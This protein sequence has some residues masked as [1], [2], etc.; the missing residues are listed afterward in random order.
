MSEIILKDGKEKNEAKIRMIGNKIA[1]TKD[2]LVKYLEE[3][4][5]KMN[6][7]V[8]L[9]IAKNSFGL[10]SV[11]NLSHD[12]SKYIQDSFGRK[13]MNVCLTNEGKSEAHYG[14]VSADSLDP[15]VDRFL[16]NKSGAKFVNER[17]SKGESPALDRYGIVSA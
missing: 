4:K 9:E 13:Y 10:V 5:I 16:Y 17:I 6:D 11:E 2:E 8:Y 7:L 12:S 1:G 15:R 14:I 3:K